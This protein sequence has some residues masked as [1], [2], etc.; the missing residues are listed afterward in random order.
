MNADSVRHLR[1][2]TG[3][4]FIECRDALKK[5]N[6]HVNLAAGYLHY[7]ALAVNVKGDREAWNMKMAAERLKG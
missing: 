6:G 2:I 5:T 7:K 3:C 1:D 4:G